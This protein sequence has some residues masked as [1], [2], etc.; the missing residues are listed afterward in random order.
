MSAKLIGSP[1]PNLKRGKP[2]EVGG[3]VVCKQGIFTDQEWGRAPRP[4]IGKAHA[5][6]GGA[7]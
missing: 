6:C 1:S 7:R 4:L 2:E 5:W 3:C